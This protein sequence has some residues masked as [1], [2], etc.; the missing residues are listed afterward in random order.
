MKQHCD[1]CGTCCR[2]GGP[3]LHLED[4]NLVK[5]GVLTLDKLITV[6][7]GEL[8]I[9]PSATQAVPALSEWIKIKGVGNDWCCH[10]LDTSS[11]L[12]TIYSNRPSSCKALK[13]WDTD[14]IIAIAGRDL[15][16]RSDLI[17]SDDPM[18]EIMQLHAK[19]CPIPDMENVFVLLT[20]ESQ[21]KNL[22]K[23]L[24]FQIKVDLKFRT[25][26]IGDFKISVAMELF[27][28]GRPL[29]QLIHSLGIAVLETPQGIE[30]QYRPS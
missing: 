23:E 30:L 27:Y 13:C 9:H 14:E 19:C 4:I 3:P 2:N 21:R 17:D 28:F 26:A 5:T 6:C 8:V 24:T 11:N 16:V 10:Y 7:C 12:C 25:Q 20:D 1:S 29:F 15:L 22:L 18:L